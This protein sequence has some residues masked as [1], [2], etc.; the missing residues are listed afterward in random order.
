MKLL[1]DTHIWLW[2]VLEPH[3]L[4]SEVHQCLS[5]S[6]ND[7]FL[8]PVSIWEAVILLEKKR[9]GIDRDIGEWFEESQ[10]ICKK[11]R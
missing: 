7:R 10:Q 3:K 4:N 8:S 9:I 6:R 2:S 1:L 5:D 11:P